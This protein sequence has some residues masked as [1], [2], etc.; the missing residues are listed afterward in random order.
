MQG[1]RGR[2]HTRGGGLCAMHRNALELD[3]VKRMETFPSVQLP[4]SIF[5]EL[6]G[7]NK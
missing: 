5:C 6:R 4:S 3:F 7:F 1:T 2:T